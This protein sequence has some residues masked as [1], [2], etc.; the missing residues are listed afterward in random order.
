[1]NR[2]GNFITQKTT[3]DCRSKKEINAVGL[4][5]NAWYS[6]Y[7]LSVIMNYRSYMSPDPKF[8]VE[9]DGSIPF[10]IQYIRLYLTEDHKYSIFY[11]DHF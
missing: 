10:D 4:E 3:I 7:G 1:M 5:S 6:G 2:L 11:H 9:I 8:Q